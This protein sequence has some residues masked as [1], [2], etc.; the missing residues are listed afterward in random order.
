ML[1]QPG[2]ARFILSRYSNFIWRYFRERPDWLVGKKQGLDRICIH[3][4]C[5]FVKRQLADVNRNDYSDFVLQ[6]ILKQIMPQFILFL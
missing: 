2:Q 4:P 1:S 5:V 3:S 6:I